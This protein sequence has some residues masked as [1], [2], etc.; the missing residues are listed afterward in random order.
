MTLVTHADTQPLSTFT[1]GLGTGIKGKLLDIGLGI[2]ETV[3]TNYLTNRFS[4]KKDTTKS[5]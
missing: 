4:G 3:I 2:A 5:V 1:I